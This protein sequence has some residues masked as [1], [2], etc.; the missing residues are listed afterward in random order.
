MALA[1]DG[2]VFPH[3]GGLDITGDDMFRA[4]EL[5]EKK[6]EM[7]VFIKTKEE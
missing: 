1:P 6:E 4:I 3:T 5:H 2:A 7:H